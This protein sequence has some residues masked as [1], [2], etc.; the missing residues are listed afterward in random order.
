MERLDYEK[1]LIEIELKL[2]AGIIDLLTLPHAMKNP[3]LEEYIRTYALAR[4]YLKDKVKCRKFEELHLVN[5][6]IIQE[7][8]KNEG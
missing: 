6:E 1:M 4:E 3:R 5:S 2:E 8:V 7:E